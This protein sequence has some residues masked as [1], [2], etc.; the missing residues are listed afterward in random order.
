MDTLEVNDEP[1]GMLMDP[2]DFESVS[3][4]T[5]EEADYKHPYW[6]N[7]MR[8][9]P[10]ESHELFAI[11]RKFTERLKDEKLQARLIHALNNQKPFATLNSTSTI[12]IT[13]RIG[14]ILRHAACKPM[15]RN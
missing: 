6:K 4:I 13:S 8:F 2:E 3:G 14:L 12:R 15:S 5:L 11:M 1:Q 10:R 7:T 9:E